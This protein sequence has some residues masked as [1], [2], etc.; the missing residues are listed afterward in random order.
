[1]TNIQRVILLQEKFNFPDFVETGTLIGTM[2]RGV[3]DRFERAFTIDLHGSTPSLVEEFGKSPR[4]FLLEGSSGDKL[5]AVLQEHKITRALFWLDAHGNE[6]HF[7]D[8]GN[9]QVPKELEAIKK[10][11]PNSLVLVDDVTH[12][13]GRVWVNSSYLFVVPGGWQ[14]RYEGRVAILH[15]GGYVLGE[16][17]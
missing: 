13:K 10:W 7:I 3:Q 15:R 17:I 16:K 14:V 12:E 9:N 6:T 2:F 8:D 4:V 11:A 5:G 1:M